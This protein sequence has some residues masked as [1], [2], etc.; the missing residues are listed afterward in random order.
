MRNFLPLLVFCCFFS[1]PVHSATTSNPDPCSLK[2]SVEDTM[3]CVTDEMRG[4]DDESLRFAADYMKGAA[5]AKLFSQLFADIAKSPSVGANAFLKS[6]F[7]NKFTKEIGG[8]RAEFLRHGYKRVAGRLSRDMSLKSSFAATALFKGAVLFFAKEV[9]YGLVEIGCCGEDT[10][11]FV[12]LKFAIDQAF[13]LLA[14]LPPFSAPGTFVAALTVQETQ[15]AIDQIIVLSEK[16]Q[17][18]KEEKGRTML[19]A[20]SG[21]AGMSKAFASA[22]AKGLP[23]SN[24]SLISI[25][26]SLELYKNQLFADSDGTDLDDFGTAVAFNLTAAKVYAA[27]PVSSLNNRAIAKKYFIAA[28]NMAKARAGDFFV[29]SSGKRYFLAFTLLRDMM[30]TYQEMVDIGVDNVFIGFCDGCTYGYSG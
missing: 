30:F 20:L 24:R 3:I 23:P 22:K 16:Y 7:A 14:S 17:E 15:I 8:K 13:A 6:A 2:T 1:A 26:Q 19:S 11:K 9:A 10:P 5:T 18:L 21:Y 28:Q 29:Q 12:G 27:K 25:T 4:S